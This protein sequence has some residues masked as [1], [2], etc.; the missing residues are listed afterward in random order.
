M[1]NIKNFLVENDCVKFQIDNSKGLYKISFP[2]ALRRIL[3][4]Y[5][6]C[7]VM[8]FKDINF[9]ENNSLFN[10]E[11]LK[12]RL[13]LIPILSNNKKINYDFIQILCQKKN[14]L[15][16]V[17]DVYVSDFKIRDR[18]TENEFKISDFFKHEDILFT[19]LQQEQYINFEANLIKNNALK[20]GS[21]F[22]PVSSCIVTF[23][24]SNYDKEKLIER[25]RNYDLNTVNEPKIYDFYYENIGFYESDELIKIGCNIL[26]ENLR[27]LKTK[28]ENY[29]I[30]NDFYM[31]N[32]DDEN[33]T[34]G[35][36]FTNYLLDNK[37]I[38]Y[39]G[40]IIEHPLKNNILVKIKIKGK[41]E[42][43]FVIINKTID[44]LIDMT[45]NILKD[46][47]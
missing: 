26:I 30:E 44:K 14:D 43:L 3:I 13:S 22:S 35:N 39:S 40:Y 31:F 45:N 38:E 47:K 7:Y 1:S 37:E 4:S 5:I 41:K 21:S 17:E 46:F 8:D 19:K 2:N 20:G 18:T 24:N 29:Y 11:F 15:H 28:F 16:T 34:L 27:K 33:D 25:E 12:S 42:D 6:D 23:N 10:N 9:I 36:L 32:I